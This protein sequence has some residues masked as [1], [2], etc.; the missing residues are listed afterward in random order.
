LDFKALAVG[1]VEDHAHLL[2]SLPATIC[3]AEAVQKLKANSSRWMHE[4]FPQ[5]RSF[6]W[7]KGY[8]AFSVGISQ[9]DATMAYI[10]RQEE[11]H[12]RVDFMGELAAFVK[13]HGLE[14]RESD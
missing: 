13:K 6:E 7:Q 1:A 14:W 10:G 12:R 8:G 4:T 5:A 9:V 11:H 2:V 3:V